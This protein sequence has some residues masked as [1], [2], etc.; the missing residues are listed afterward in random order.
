ML[1]RCD[2]SGTWSTGRRTNAKDDFHLGFTNFNPPNKSSNDLS[3][4]IPIEIVQA[5]LHTAG[6]ILQ[7]SDDQVKIARGFNF[8]QQ[9]VPAL[10]ELTQP[11]LEAG[12]PWLEVLPL[13]ESFRIAVDQAVDGAVNTADLA[14]QG[15][16]VMRRTSSIPRLC[17]PAFI[18]LGKTTG[19]LQHTANLIPH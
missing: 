2:F 1:R 16:L 5:R 15:D 17:K 4:S 11:L 7:L 8:L 6:K 13:D 3:L 9:S 19:I 18:L 10:F 12:D 14:I